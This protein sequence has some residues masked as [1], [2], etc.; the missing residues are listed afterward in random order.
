MEKYNIAENQIQAD[1]FHKVSDSYTA[2]SGK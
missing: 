2:Y 1:K